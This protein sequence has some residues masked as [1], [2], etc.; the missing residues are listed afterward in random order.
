MPIIVYII[1]IVY[2]LAVNLYGILMLNFQ[3]NSR[4]HGEEESIPVSDV[5]L[6]LTGALGG[7]IGIFTFMFILKYRLKS[8]LMMVLMPI[9]ITLN[10]YII[11][12]FFSQGFSFI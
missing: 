8:L 1:V 4:E 10:V 9:F 6:L 5:K 11:Y 12:M 3:K 7:A 2:L